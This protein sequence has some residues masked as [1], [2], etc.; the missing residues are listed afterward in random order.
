[1]GSVGTQ[2]PPKTEEADG[3]L[4]QMKQAKGLV[5]GPLVNPTDHMQ[6]SSQRSWGGDDFTSLSKLAIKAAELRKVGWLGRQPKFDNYAVFHNPKVQQK[7][8]H[9]HATVESTSVYLY[10][11]SRAIALDSEGAS[12]GVS[13]G[14]GC[15]PSLGTAEANVVAI[16]GLHLTG[17][18]HF[19]REQLT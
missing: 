17:H 10:G 18:R 4:H 11:E 7:H 3:L 15:S 12:H 16:S 14:S 9:V 19:T 13:V 6:W 1:M 2:S 5:V 8:I